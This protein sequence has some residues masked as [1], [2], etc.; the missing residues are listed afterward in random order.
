MASTCTRAMNPVPMMPAR[1]A[2][3]DMINAR[4]YR[5]GPV[6]SESLPLPGISLADCGGCLH[7][8]PLPVALLSSPSLVV[9]FPSQN[10]GSTG[11]LFE[12]QK[13]LQL[14]YNQ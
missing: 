4:A 1:T 8:T 5:K 10:Q 9:V 6:P 11:V 14:L 12:R 7:Q 13:E 2:D 3:W